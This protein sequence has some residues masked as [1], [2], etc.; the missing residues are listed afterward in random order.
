MAAKTDT[1]TKLKSYIGR[2]GNSPVELAYTEVE[3]ERYAARLD[4]SAIALQHQVQQLESSVRGVSRVR[5]CR[6]IVEASIV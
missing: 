1:L 4:K 3:L 5:I 6:D 2:P